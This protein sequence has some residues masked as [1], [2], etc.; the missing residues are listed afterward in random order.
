MMKA[1]NRSS[2]YEPAMQ[3][4][5]CKSRGLPE[6]VWKSHNVR[7]TPHPESMVTCPT[8]LNNK[9]S[10]CK[11]IGHLVSRCPVKKMEEKYAKRM[12]YIERAEA[13]KVKPK[14]VVVS[15]APKNSFAALEVDSDSDTEECIEPVVTK[16]R[17][18]NWADADSDSED[19]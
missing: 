4:T 10:H 1:M 8:I 11:E 14:T 2:N 13:L 12:A 3:C 6:S 17:P 7:K 19:E 18:F 16:K 5:V 15:E 9:C